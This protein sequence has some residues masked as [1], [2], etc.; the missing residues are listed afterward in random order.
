MV[1]FKYILMITL[2]LVLMACNSPVKEAPKVS[3]Q[4]NIIQKPII[5]DAKREE[6]SL[7][8]LSTRY[9]MKMDKAQITPKMVVVHWTA[10][11]TLEASFNAFYKPML[12]S[13]RSKISSAS[14][15]NVSAHYLIDRD[16]TIYQLLPNTTFARHVIGLNHSA[17]GIENVGN[18]SNLPLTAEQLTANIELI[19]QLSKAYPIEYVIG[20]HEYRNFSKHPLWKEVNPNYLTVKTDPGET[21]MT[22]I[23]ASLTDLNLKKVP[24]L[25]Q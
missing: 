1:I 23:R 19:K 22:N 18:G 4:L 17:I 24:E 12:P 9:N 8:Y 21:F 6:L 7:E 2:L 14:Q 25:K 15:L 5:Y 3:S 16:G 10:I 20:H 11:P 13:F